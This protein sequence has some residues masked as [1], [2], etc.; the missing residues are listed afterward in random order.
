M[1]IYQWLMILLVSSIA[2]E[3]FLWG[4]ITY[5]EIL[6]TVKLRELENKSSLN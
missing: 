3:S 2:A 4:A 5:A 1:Q 6:K